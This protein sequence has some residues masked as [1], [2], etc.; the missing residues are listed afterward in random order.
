MLIEGR[1][2][3]APNPVQIELSAT[4][5]KWLAAAADKRARFRDYRSRRD[6]WGPG[7]IAN[8]IFVGLT[9]EHGLC[10][11]LNKHAGCHAAIDAALRPNGDGGCDVAALGLSFQVKTRLR[12]TS[13]L[14]RRVTESKRIAAVDPNAVYVF[15]RW[16][17]RESVVYLLGWIWGRDAVAVAIQERSAVARHWNLRLGDDRL[18]SMWR[19][20]DE[21]AFRRLA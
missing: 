20:C 21:L 4:D 6:S 2:V 10:V 13:N 12:G 17:P 11:F 3:V 16:L 1:G 7:I 18:E 19:L 14:I 5:V 8:P 15:A 9:G